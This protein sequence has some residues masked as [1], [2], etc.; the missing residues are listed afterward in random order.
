MPAHA[1]RF[2]LAVVLA[3]TA[4]L[5][6]AHP[7][8]AA[9]AG[10]D[11]AESAFI[12]E[13][14]VKR[15]ERIPMR[16]GARLFTAVYVPKDASAERRYPILLQRTPFPAGPY[17][18]AAHPRTLGPSP[19]MLR[20]GYIYVMQEVRG[21]YLSEGEFENVRPLLADSVRARDPGAVDEATDAFD[22]IEWLVH[23]LP[24][25]NGRVGLLGISYGGYYAAAAA[26]SGHPAIAATSLQA[27]VMD[28]F[29]EDFHHNG[30]LLLGHFY[31]YPVFGVARPQPGE[32]H[33]WLSEFQRAAG[34]DTGDDYADLLALG[35]LRNVTEGVYA[36]NR[37]WREMVAHP[38]YDAFWRARAMAPRLSRVRHPVLVTGGWFDAENL[39]GTLEAYR[40]LRVGPGRENVSLVMGPFAHRGWAE[41]GVARTTH[42]DLYFG[43]S[44]QTAYQR[45]V[46]AP[47]FRAH[48]TG[49]PVR[50]PA[51]A[52]VFD[53]GRRAW[54]R[55]AAW[56]APPA[57]R[58]DFFLRADGSLA[59]SP[60]AAGPAFVEYTSDPRRP[61]PSRCSGPTIEDGVLVRYMSDDQRCFTTRPDVVV[62]RTEPLREDVTFGGPLTARLW[63]STTG[64]DADF[65]VKLID[66]YPPASADDAVQDDS[67][68]VRLT[69]YQQLVRGEIMRG[70]FRQ[71]F[72]APVAFQPNR[73]TEVAVPLPDV[74]HTFRKGHRVMVQVQS[75]WFPLFDRNPQRYVP[76]IYQARESDFIRATH[77]VWMSPGAA[78]RLEA[79]VIGPGS[80]AAAIR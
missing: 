4:A 58:Q 32:S 42:G 78:S 56:P 3:A 64:T 33:W 11:D 37:W 47:W 39:Y 68:A 30:A 14:Y 79:R 41:R 54:E 6:A 63:V 27:P 67:A 10:D 23:H 28:F 48:L 7:T 34:I 40:A 29:F 43:D 55:F 15:E 18:P 17:G 31:S 61:V 16:D 70:R 26:Q 21:R 62:F 50:E 35:P 12:A 25:Q 73:T 36:Q 2:R 76:S 74:F 69:G 60:Q 80:A 45:D 53:T 13:H 46:E 51:G 57:A 65:V 77:R 59:S 24:E 72:S 38:D 8:L 22:T 66:V 19:F 75:S 20:D 52:L 1:T 44:L 71:S 9:Q 5:L 49:E